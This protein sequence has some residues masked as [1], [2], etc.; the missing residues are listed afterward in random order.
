M[1]TLYK[2]YLGSPHEEFK[3][4][5]IVFEYFSGFTV[6]RATGFWM[7]NPEICLVFEILDDV[8]GLGDKVNDLAIHLKEAFKQQCVLVT[9]C[10]VMAQVI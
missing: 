9:A 8:G 6:Y 1:K 10:Q 4:Y 3:A 2:I 7:S 5:E